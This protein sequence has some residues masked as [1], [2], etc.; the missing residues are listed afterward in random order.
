MRH[1]LTTISTLVILIISIN[2]QA[3]DKVVVIP[4]G[5]SAKSTNAC[6]WHYTFIGGEYGTSVCPVNTHAI[7]GSCGSIGGTLQSSGPLGVGGGIEPA[8]NATGWFCQAT[9]GSALDVRALCCP[10]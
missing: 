9:E 4:L 6:N 7:S 3:A 2:G 5:D 8:Q 1:L 10:N